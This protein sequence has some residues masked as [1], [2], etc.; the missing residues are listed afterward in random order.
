MQEIYLETVIIGVLG[1]LVVIE[2]LLI[3]KSRTRII[4]LE[5]ALG[6]KGLLSIDEA[7]L[8]SRMHKE[9]LA[10][11]DWLRSLRYQIPTMDNAKLEA[12]KDELTQT[13]EMYC[14]VFDKDLT[15]KV[16]DTPGLQLK[17]ALLLHI[18]ITIGLVEREIVAK[19]YKEPSPI[20]EAKLPSRIDKEILVSLDWLRSLR[21]Q[22]PTMDRLVLEALKDELTDTHEMY[23][24]AFG[25]DLLE[26]ETDP[27]DS[28]LRQARLLHI[29]IAIG[30]VEKALATKS[31]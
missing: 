11:L 4:E 17:Q 24:E 3:M 13:H 10:S 1:L 26:E 15:G 25:K 8:P 9:I 27:F 7:K 18:E 6:P 22:I 12:L 16:T 29:E 28:Q 30:L 14:E 23:C 21:Y 5:I 2:A 31:F 20:G 19:L